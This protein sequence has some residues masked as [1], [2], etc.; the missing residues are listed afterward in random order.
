MRCIRSR[1][2][3]HQLGIRR[4]L[5]VQRA[6]ARVRDRYPAHL[7][8]VVRRDDH[9]Q[10]GGQLAVPPDELRAI[11]CERDF[12]AVRLDAPGLIAGRPNLTTAHVTQEDVTAPVVARAVLAPARHADIAP[13]A[14]P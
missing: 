5:D 11:L 3:Q 1:G 8:M 14:V 9:V 7:R 13:A 6:A 4:D 2:R 10:R 12:V